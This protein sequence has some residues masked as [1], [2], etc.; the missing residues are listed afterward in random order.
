MT[1]VPQKD[2]GT[3]GGIRGRRQGCAAMRLRGDGP[4]EEWVPECGGTHQPMIFG[5]SA[6]WGGLAF[7]TYCAG[8]RKP[9]SRL[10]VRWKTS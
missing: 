7:D 5:E 3:L 10:S 6:G 9:A 2:Q 4:V 1:C 8:R